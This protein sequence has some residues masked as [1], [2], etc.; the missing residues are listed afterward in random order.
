MDLRDISSTLT[1]VHSTL[2]ACWAVATRHTLNAYDLEAEETAAQRVTELRIALPEASGVRLLS[3]QSELLDHLVHLRNALREAQVGTLCVNVYACLQGWGHGVC[4]CAHVRLGGCVE[5]SGGVWGR[6]CAC[7]SACVHAGQLLRLCMSMDVLMNLCCK[8]EPCNP[9]W[10]DMMWTDI[11]Q[12][13]EHV[14]IEFL[15][16]SM[17]C[18]GPTTVALATAPAPVLY[19]AAQPHWNT[20]F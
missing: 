9:A 11:V 10:R 5:V 19:D 18:L 13:C 17:D 8:G 14:C 16:A 4:A 20:M 1:S 7:L 2:Q 12:S 3:S 15:N 6:W